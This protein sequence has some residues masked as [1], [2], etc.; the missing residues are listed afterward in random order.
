MIRVKK[1]RSG[2]LSLEMEYHCREDLFGR[3]CSFLETESLRVYKLRERDEIMKYMA[4]SI[5]NEFLKRTNF[6]LQEMI[7][8]RLLVKRS[9]ATAIMWLLRDADADSIEMIDLKGSLHK[10]LI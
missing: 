3:I 9:E 8:M 2:N 7:T 10:Q 1:L 4:Y 5:L 6:H